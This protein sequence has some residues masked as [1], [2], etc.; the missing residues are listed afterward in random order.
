VPEKNAIF[1]AALSVLDASTT[2]VSFS[3]SNACPKIPVSLAALPIETLK[4]SQFAASLSVLNAT[5]SIMP[6]LFATSRSM[7]F[8]TATVISP[9]FA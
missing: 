9:T 3:P 8:E 1:S 5:V 4:L 2:K 7:I 6:P